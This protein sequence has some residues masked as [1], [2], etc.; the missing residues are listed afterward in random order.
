MPTYVDS[1]I[2]G[3]SIIDFSSIG[4]EVVYVTFDTTTIP[5]RAGHAADGISDHYLRIGWF[6]LGDSFDIGT[7]DT[8]RWCPI[9]WWNFQNNIWTPDPSTGEGG[10]ALRRIATRVRYYI[11]PGGAGHMHIFGL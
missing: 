6:A 9:T 8:L 5:T 1:D 2:S 3:D 7:G 11:Y 4:N 10:G